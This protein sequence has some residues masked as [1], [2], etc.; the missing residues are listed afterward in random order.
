MRAGSEGNLLW[1]QSVTQERR[2]S[3][4]GL[5]Q[6][7]NYPMECAAPQHKPAEESG[8]DE[9]K[10][11]ILLSDHLNSQSKCYEAAFYALK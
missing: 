4:A 1:H 11:K 10:G 7:A 6:R 5:V 8:N 9:C 3:L 2:P